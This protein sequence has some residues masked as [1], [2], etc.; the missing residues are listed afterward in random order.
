M[1]EQYIEI[2]IQSLSKKLEV[3]HEIQEQNEQQR[4][5]LLDE[6]LPP[7]DLEKNLEAKAELVEQLNLLDEGFDEVY[8]R[9][10]EALSENP[11][12]YRR[13]I[14]LLQKQI[15]EVTSAGSQVQAQEKR[16]Y[17]LAARKFSSVKKQI[18]EVKASHQ[19][20]NQ[21]YRNMMKLNFVDPQFMD[22]K[23]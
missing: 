21:Y 14:A 19:A 15:R 3:L 9:V 10:R 8:Q 4:V 11:S 7:E 1:Q 12:A 17:D 16:N 5:L 22:N 23:K 6:N 13:Q 18:R 2:L 20:V